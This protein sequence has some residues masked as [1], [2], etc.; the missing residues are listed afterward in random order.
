[1]CNFR[2]DNEFSEFKGFGCSEVSVPQSI[3]ESIPQ[4]VLNS[5]PPINF[6]G[7]IKYNCELDYD[8]NKKLLEFKLLE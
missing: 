2:C 3:F 7:E 8:G 4:S 1:M 6:K 5:P